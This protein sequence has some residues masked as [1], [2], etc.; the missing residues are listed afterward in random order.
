MSQ[1][2]Y[3]DVEA[4][5]ANSTVDIVTW[6]R[7]QDYTIGPNSFWSQGLI[8]YFLKPVPERIYNFHYGNGVPE[9]FTLVR[10]WIL[11]NQVWKIRFDKLDL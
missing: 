4:D 3:R 7:G 6:D 9:M 1:R 10:T 5:M 2:A 8:L 11:K